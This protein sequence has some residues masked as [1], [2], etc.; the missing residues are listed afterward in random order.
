MSR[1]KQNSSSTS[2]TERLVA[3]T[4]TPEAEEKLAETKKFSA[5]G[6]PERIFKVMTNPLTKLTCYFLKSNM[7][8]FDEFN[9]L[10]QRDEP[11]IH[12]L[13]TKCIQLLTDLFVRFLKG[14]ALRESKEILK[15]EYNLRSNQKD[16]KDLSIG[17]DTKTYL[18]ECLSKGDL[19]AKERKD[20]YE[21]VR[22]YFVEACRY[23]LVRFPI[24]S[25]FLK[26][27]EVVDIKK[28][29][30]LLKSLKNNKKQKT[31]RNIF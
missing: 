16:D 7:T 12:E 1:S 6:R 17:I 13:Q 29:L 26:H 4:S 25:E 3:S 18:D 30:F 22:R 2:R 5:I 27:S 9:L 21:S 8:L 15:I 31:K 24:H 28:F 20:F 14:S 11:L 10:L 19:C 23:I